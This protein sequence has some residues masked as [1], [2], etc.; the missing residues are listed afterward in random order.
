MVGPGDA[1]DHV[2]PDPTLEPV[3]PELVDPGGDVDRTVRSG[4]ELR[5]DPAGPRVLLRPQPAPDRRRP[6]PQP[7]A[8]ARAKGTGA[9]EQCRDGQPAVGAD[10]EFDV[11]HVG[12]RKP[13]GVDDLPVEEVQPGVVLAVEAWLISLSGHHWPPRVRIMSGIAAD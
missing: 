12:D 1:V 7:A 4:D 3:D 11:V 13:V 5:V 9:A 2:P 10:D 8:H 6:A